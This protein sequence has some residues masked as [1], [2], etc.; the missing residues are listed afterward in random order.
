LEAALYN[1]IAAKSPV[2]DAVGKAS[3]FLRGVFDKNK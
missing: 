2:N 1:S 3:G